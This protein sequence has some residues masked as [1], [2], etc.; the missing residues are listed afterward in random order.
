M[1]VGPGKSRPRRAAPR[2]G[3]S[4]VQP[5]S[6]GLDCCSHMPL[7]LALIMLTDLNVARSFSGAHQETKRI[8]SKPAVEEQFDRVLATP[9]DRVLNCTK[10]RLGTNGTSLVCTWKTR[11]PAFSETLR[12]SFPILQSNEHIR[13]VFDFPLVS[14]RR[15]RNVR[16]ILVSPST[17]QSRKARVP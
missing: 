14:Y 2:S 1:R 10:R 3:C 4:P 5:K 9:R 6:E 17:E 7:Q 15:P 11:L 12:D 13:S 16:D 8:D